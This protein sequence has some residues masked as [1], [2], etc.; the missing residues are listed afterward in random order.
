MEL[1]VVKPIKMLRVILSLGLISLA[2]MSLAD[3]RPILSLVIDDLG[4][5]FQKG[6]EAIALDGDHTYAL[7]PGTAYSK[8]LATLA[9][10][11]NKEIILHLPLQALDKGSAMEANVLNEAM[12]E[13]LLFENLNVMLSEFPGIRGVNNHMG[14][15]LTA[16]DYFMKPIM[17]GIKSYNPNLY[18]LDSRTTPNSTAYYQAKQS[19]LD[20][21]TR[22]VFLDHDKD[23]LASIKLQF[24]I[25][26]QKARDRGSAIAIGH[27]HV[28]TIEFLREN[29]GNIRDEFRIQSIS[30]LI[31][32]VTSPEIRK[33]W[34]N[35]ASAP[36]EKVG[37][38]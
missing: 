3:Q 23:N 17:D 36:V 22:D 33:E 13:N 38:L 11:S 7:I 5:S 29:L 27:P 2:S 10:E 30:K 1:R 12:D 9:K 4:Y 32:E 31:S 21:L 16:I 20:S 37:N 26:L 28:M 19:G 18:F 8:K 24:E 34:R 14:S 25:W 15:H 35:S 6:K